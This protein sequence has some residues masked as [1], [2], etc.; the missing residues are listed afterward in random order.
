MY[1]FRDIEEVEETL[2]GMM[3]NNHPMVVRLPR[4]AG[5]KERRCMHLFSGQP[6]IEATEPIL[7]EEPATL[8]VRSENSRITAMENEIAALRKE[9]EVLA[10]EFRALKSQFE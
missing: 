7:R 1:K 3:N 10:G 8:Q 9:L 5:R 2:Q 6:D 4:Q